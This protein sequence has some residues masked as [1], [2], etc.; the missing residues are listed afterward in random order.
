M[1]LTKR[2]AS[3]ATSVPFLLAALLAALF[4]AG[5]ATT[6]FD[7]AAETAEAERPE[8]ADSLAE[9]EKAEKKEEERRFIEEEL[10]T[11]DIESTVVYVDRPVYSPVE[12][13]EKQPSG[14]E[15]VERSAGSALQTPM[16][17]V[18]GVMFYPWDETFV[19]E[20]H[21]QPY[22]VTDLILE[23]G[24]EVLEMPFLSEEKVW[25]IG[26]GVSRENGLDVQHFFL[27]PSYSALATSMIVITTKRVYHL[28]LKSFKDRYMAMVRW[29]YPRS[30]PFTVKQAAGG[31]N[32]NS[33]S[34]SAALVDPAF[35]SF[36]YKMTYSLFRKPVW[37]P[38]RAYDDGRKTYIELDERTLHM[39]SPVL[40]DG[41]SR[42]VNYR[43][44]KNLII[45][46]ELIEKVTLKRGREK[47]TVVK[48]TYRGPKE[49]GRG[50]TAVPQDAEE[51]R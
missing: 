23:P 19:Y 30:M 14:A 10:K 8:G 51:R 49:G 22:R 3:G 27:K 21:C 13:P 25:E 6:H 29:E 26:A 9:E 2:A 15:A 35:L 4:T 20:I 31:K 39:E 50:E 32:S 5:C 36:D 28:L 33:L 18:N 44:W 48:K 40:F 38:K 46:D 41:K 34:Q 45:I 47:V 1:K 16:K 11:V 7:A 42:R 12:T 43:V 17:F 37:L 24:E